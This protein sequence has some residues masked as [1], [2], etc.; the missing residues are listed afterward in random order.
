VYTNW[1]SVI[2]PKAMAR[3]Q[4]AFWEGAIGKAVQSEEW[5]RDLERNFWTANFLTGEPARRYVEQQ[6]ELFRSI[7]IELGLAKNA[8]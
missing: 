5:S 6:G 2:G 7:F 3:P 8:K 4:V 1:R